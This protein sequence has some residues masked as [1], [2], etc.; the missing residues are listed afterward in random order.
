MLVLS[1]KKGE[2][3]V[4]GQDIQVTVLEVR[5]DRVKLGFYGPGD[6]L[7]RREELLHKPQAAQSPSET[8]L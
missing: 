8:T 7:I 4:I 1:R 3:V 2:R 6:V 5:G